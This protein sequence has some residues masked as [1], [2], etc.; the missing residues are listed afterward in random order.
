MTF[1]QLQGDTEQKYINITS[2]NANRVSE[3]KQVPAVVYRL[4][5]D[6]VLPPMIIYIPSCVHCY[7]D[8]TTDSDRERKSVSFPGV[9]FVL[10]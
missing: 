9:H 5:I 4:F 8:R 7:S 1:G 10:T 2:S 3:D 6:F